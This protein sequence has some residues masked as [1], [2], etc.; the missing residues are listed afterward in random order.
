MKN[1]VLAAVFLM[2]SSFVFAQNTASTEVDLVYNQKKERFKSVKKIVETVKDRTIV[3]LGEG[4]H[5]TKEFNVIRSEIAK[6]LMTKHNVR[7]LAFESAFGDSYFLNKG[8]NSEQ[9]MKQVMRDYLLSIW[10][11]KE[12]EDLF[13]WIRAYNKKHDDKIVV[14]G[15]DIN[16]L[17][18]SAV[19]LENNALKSNGAYSSLVDNLKNKAGVLDNAW[20]QSNNPSYS[21]DMK[22]LIKNGVE[23]YDMVKKIDS[24]FADKLDRDAVL[25]LKNLK[26]GFENFY[27]A[28]KEDYTFDRDAAMAENIMNIESA[29]NKKMV[30]IAHNGHI[31]L[32]PTLITGMGGFLKK[33][34]GAAYYALATFSSMGSYSAMTDNVDTKNNLFK[35]YTFPAVLEN[36]WELKMSQSAFDNYFVDFETDK[37]NRY[38]EALRMRFIG[39]NPVVAGKET[40]TIVEPIQLNKCFDGFVFIKSSNAAEHF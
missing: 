19:I 3:A 22:S 38:N 20:T 11:T 18:N 25:A 30:V 6:E 2:F 32:Q 37:S 9:D 7:L 23:G 8:I 21:L 29:Y 17:T 16:F 12:F 24:L 5:G 26:L 4:T 39:Y 33:K 27:R 28:S 36:S 31:S 35:P 34:Y 1:K 14:T 13:L 40:Y 15:F 10:Q